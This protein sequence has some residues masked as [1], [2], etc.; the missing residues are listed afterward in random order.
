MC[1]LSPI[2]DGEIDPFLPN[3]LGNQNGKVQL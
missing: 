1:Q 3:D 2:E